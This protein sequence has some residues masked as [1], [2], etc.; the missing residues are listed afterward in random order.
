M[1][2][3]TR[4]KKP[5]FIQQQ[6]KVEEKVVIKEKE[7][8]T[9]KNKFLR[10][11]F[12]NYK[13]LLIIPMIML[14]LAITL[15]GVKMATTGDFI[16]RGVSLK[17]G[18][19]FTITDENINTIELEKT[20]KDN[21]P[22][23]DISTRSLNEG[24]RQIGATIEVDI[25]DVDDINKVLDIFKNDFNLEKDDYT[26]ETM[27]SS[28]GESF[29]KQTFRALILAFV[30]MAIVV[31]LYFRTFAPSIAVVLAAFSDIIVTVAIVNLMGIKLT[32]AGIAAFLMLIGYSVD[33]DILL[34]T[35]V[36]KAKEG[37]VYT[38]VLR[39]MKTGLTMTMTTI[40]AVIV[41]L[42]V[43]ESQ[44]IIQIMTIIL[45]GLLVDI[46]N[47]WIQNVA[48]LRLYLERKNNERN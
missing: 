9:G 31:F 37:T 29:F 13:K 46:I 7:K 41:A 1:S 16:N 8:Y 15:I 17:G 35:K 21:L 19:T 26:V 38:N 10:F 6:S 33:T 14:L 4:K 2:K 12:N 36:L 11:Y 18:T 45:I 34:T 39:A 5:A 32:T 47:T 27:G 40:G 43:A 48:I 25:T 20:L 42:I 3:K 28:L 23:F 22:G 24:S 30:F 44:V